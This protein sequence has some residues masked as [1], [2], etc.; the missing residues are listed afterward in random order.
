VLAVLIEWYICTLRGSKHTRVVWSTLESRGKSLTP[1]SSMLMDA[2]SNCM[3]LLS[4][5]THPSSAMIAREPICDI[6]AT[7]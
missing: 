5:D 1:S 3:L 2:S 7:V 4:E 6:Q